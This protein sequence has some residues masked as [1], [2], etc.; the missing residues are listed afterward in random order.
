ME[1]KKVLRDKELEKVTGG[2]N[3]EFEFGKDVF[4]M[5][6][7]KALHC[8]IDGNNAAPSGGGKYAEEQPASVDCSG[9]IP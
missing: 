7:K 3:H 9:L 8:G 4:A 5:E 6:D 1:D 2:N